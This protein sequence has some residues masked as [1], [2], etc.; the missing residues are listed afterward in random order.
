[1][2]NKNPIKPNIIVLHCHDLGRFLG[3]YGIQTVSMPNLDRLASEGVLFDNAF[4]TASLCSPSRAAMFTGRYPHQNGVMGLTG[5]A[6]GWE[7]HPSE[8]HIAQILLQNGYATEAV[9][10]IHETGENP[11]CIGFNRHEPGQRAREVSSAAIERLNQL[12]RADKPFY[13]QAGCYEP[14]RMET[15]IP[16]ADQTFLGPDLSPDDSMGVTVPGYLK[17]T[18]GARDEM[19]ELQ[20][21]VKHMDHH[22]G[23]ILKAIDDLGLGSNTIVVFTTDHG[24][25]MPR[26]KCTLYDPGIEAALMIRF[27]DS[28]GKA[29]KV[30]SLVSNLDLFPTLLD[31]A[32]IPVPEN[33]EGLSLLPLV[34]GRTDSARSHIMA[35]M[36]CVGGFYHPMRCIRTKTHKLIVNFSNGRTVYDPSSSLRPRS[37]TVFPLNTVFQP[38]VPVELYDLDVDPLEHHNIA[39][40]FDLRPLR[41]EML[42]ALYDIMKRTE[43]PILSGP[44]PT[45]MHHAAVNFLKGME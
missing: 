39:E 27:P 24:I 1:M 37:D 10:V 43:D 22:M 13:L 5:R 18:S 36:T 35:E 29:T 33:T 16:G 23:L 30:S 42:A 32:G 21:A 3:C 40:K 6:A 44:I 15:G 12:A 8:K 17:D 28:R 2:R 34:H 14:H 7:L 20:G 26:A 38:R 31:L 45:A 4:C 11:Q 19:S 41:R 9:G 25:A